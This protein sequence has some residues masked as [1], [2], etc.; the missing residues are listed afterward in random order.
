MILKT[1]S[2]SCIV[3]GDMQMKRYPLN[4]TYFLYSTTGLIL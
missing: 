2:V 1:D 3:Y 4:D